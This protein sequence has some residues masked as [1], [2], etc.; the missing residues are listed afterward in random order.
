MP[1]IAPEFHRK[2]P[3]NLPILLETKRIEVGKWFDL[4]T[5]RLKNYVS[6]ETSKSG[7]A[8]SI[9]AISPIHGFNLFDPDEILSEVK[10]IM[11]VLRRQ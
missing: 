7:A 9:K 8:N 11:A 10:T 2:N 3:E 5:C 6:I 1:R 4:I